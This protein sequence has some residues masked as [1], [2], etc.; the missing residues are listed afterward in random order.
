MIM[1]FGP[2]PH[3]LAVAALWTIVLSL[4]AIIGGGILGLCVTLL[5][6][7]K[8]RVVARAAE[9][10]I[11]LVQG[12][13]L[14]VLL[15]ICYFGMSILGVDLSAFVAVTIAFSIYASAFL[16]EI[17]RGAIEAVPKTQWE[18]SACLGFGRFHQLRD[19]ILPQAVRISIP[20]T[21]GFVVQVIKNTSLASVVGFVDLTRAGQV[22][23]N[24]TFRP[25]TVFLAI[26][27]IYFCI[28]YPLSILSKKLEISL[29][30]AN[31]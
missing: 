29:N 27:A 28:C 15:F 26:A 25:F 23:N 5:R 21:V 3:Y 13:P 19:V 9:I 24:A 7:S 31:R 22:I 8:N 20:P 6:I 1:N 30:V 17:W 18:A 16:G 14:L 11:H 12:L 2:Y 4:V 10:Y